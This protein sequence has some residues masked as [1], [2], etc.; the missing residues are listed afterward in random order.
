MRVVI[1]L[2]G[3]MCGQNIHELVFLPRADG[4]DISPPFLKAT[5]G[6][7]GDVNFEGTHPIHPDVSKKLYTQ[8]LM[9][10]YD[11]IWTYNQKCKYMC[12]WDRID[13]GRSC[14]LF[15]LSLHAWEEIDLYVLL[16]LL[17]SHQ[18]SRG[19]LISYIGQ[20]Q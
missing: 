2:T 13:D 19:S 10:R 4:M 5:V 11:G 18:D 8:R 6:N 17:F 12:V 20:S 1:L 9:N 15:S 3:D 16:L 14:C 7:D